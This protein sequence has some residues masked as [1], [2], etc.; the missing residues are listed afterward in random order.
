MVC[1]WEGVVRG[2]EGGSCK[3]KLA[4]SEHIT[5][6]Y[7]RIGMRH[8]ELFKYYFCKCEL[9]VALFFSVPSQHTQVGSVYFSGPTFLILAENSLDSLLK[10]TL[11]RTV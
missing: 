9:G 4:I 1:E 6:C 5:V 3:C 7:V 11:T 8:I 10:Y 2:W